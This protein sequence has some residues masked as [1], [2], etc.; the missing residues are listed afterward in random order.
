MLVN[1]TFTTARAFVNL[2]LFVGELLKGFSGT[3]DSEEAQSPL[4]ARKFTH[5]YPPTTVL[6]IML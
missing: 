4:P 2:K 5:A 3:M 6:H 1:R